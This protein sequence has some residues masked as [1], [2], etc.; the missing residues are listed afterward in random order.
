MGKLID[1][2]GR[3]P[4]RAAGVVA[5][6][7]IV[8]IGVLISCQFRG[9]FRETAPLTLLAPRAGLVLDP[10]SKVTYNGVV[11]GRLTGVAAQTVDGTPKARLALEI[12]PKYQSLIPANV[13]AKVS[14]TTVFGNKY[15]AFT[16]PEHPSAQRISSSDVIDVAGVTT[17]FNT[18]FET[19][20]SISQRVDP[21]KLNLT[22]TAAADAL[23]GLGTKFGTALSNGSDIL[24]HLNPRLPQLHSD[25]QSLSDLADVYSAASPDLWTF[26][27]NA[28]TTA[29][30]LR[31]QQGDLDAALLA[32]VGFGNAGADA[33]EP[34]GPYLVR[35]AA[36]L[37]PSSALFDEYSPEFFCTL[38][39]FA[40]VSPLV[41]GALG[42]S[43]GYSLASYSG[44]G[45]TGVPNPYIYP[46]NLPRVNAKGGP[47]G[48]PGCWQ[49]IT[50][51]LWPAP[52]L[53]MDTGASLAP[54]NHFELGQPLLVEHVWGRQIGEYTIN[55]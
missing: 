32:A 11:I 54:Y 28:L 43:N 6:L 17:E 41:S 26:L 42:G 7:L 34:A 23:T 37:I 44:G 24:D 22:L 21:V 4:L 19:V 20:T 12:Y 53:V 55:P 13:V 46:D 1:V 40:L 27:D 33:F 51:D 38:R 16:S 18:L 45:V 35:G 3:P 49:S 39:N 25:V 36:D 15:I 29:H 2:R 8:A 5:L 31:E 14:A 52:Y 47:G 30:T 50:R 48:K 10:G 9:E